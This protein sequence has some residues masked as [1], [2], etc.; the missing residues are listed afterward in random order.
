VHQLLSFLEREAYEQGL[1]RLTIEFDLKQGGWIVG[2][3]SPPLSALNSENPPQERIYSQVLIPAADFAIGAID[4]HLADLLCIL[5]R[6][7]CG[8]RGEVCAFVA[9]QKSEAAEA[10]SLLHP[11]DFS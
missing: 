10:A 3:S 7:V 4:E 8:P 1:L 9:T 6:S 5:R 2:F 11:A